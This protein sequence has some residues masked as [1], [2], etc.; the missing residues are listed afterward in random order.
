MC[1]LV[2]SSGWPSVETSK[3]VRAA[4]MAKLENETGLRLSGAFGSTGPESIGAIVCCYLL[5]D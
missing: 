1:V 2:T 5:F 3:T 4:P